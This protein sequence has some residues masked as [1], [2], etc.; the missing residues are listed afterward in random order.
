MVYG[1][2]ISAR[3]GSLQLRTPEKNIHCL[4]SVDGN[5]APKTID[6]LGCWIDSQHLVNGRSDVVGRVSRG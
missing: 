3:Y 2:G 4:A 5:G 6:H 1:S